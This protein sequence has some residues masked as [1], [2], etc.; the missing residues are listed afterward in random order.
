MTTYVIKGQNWEKEVE[1][2]ES[3][4]ETNY[5]ASME[6]ATRLI[7]NNKDFDE[8]ETMGVFLEAYKKEDGYLGD[9]H[10]FLKTSEVLGNASLFETAVF[11]EELYK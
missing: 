10:A 4:F 3:V 7:E 6:A 1:I 5:S 11:I 8:S 2:D 9:S